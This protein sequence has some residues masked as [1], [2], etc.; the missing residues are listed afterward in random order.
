M[1]PCDSPKKLEEKTRNR[2]FHSKC[3]RYSGF[4]ALGLFIFNQNIGAD[5]FHLDEANDPFLCHVVTAGAIKSNNY[6]PYIKI[7]FQAHLKQHTF[8]VN[9]VSAIRYR[10]KSTQVLQH[11]V[12]I[13]FHKF[14]ILSN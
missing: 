11:L 1:K 5:V 6:T 12:I 2:I 8:A 13:L 14:S 4:I 7:Y 10:I 3:V 9:N